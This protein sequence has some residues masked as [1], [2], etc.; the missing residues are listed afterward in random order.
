MR[1]EERRVSSDARYRVLSALV[2]HPLGLTRQALASAADVP[3]ATLATI[4][5]G[6][7]GQDLSAL[8]VEAK[9]ERAAPGGGP[10]PKIVRLREGICV[11]GV[12]IGHG[13]IRVGIAGLDGR[14]WPDA[15]GRH[16]DQLVMPVFKE[17]RATLNWIAGGLEGERGALSQRLARVFAERTKN[18]AESSLKKPLVVG[19]GISV[20]GPVDPQDGRLVCVRPADGLIKD[21]EGSIACADWDGESAGKGLRD[22]LRGAD[23]TEMFGWTLSH[24]RSDSASELCAKAELSRGVLSDT[25]FAIFVKWTGNV[26][27]AVVLGGEVF[28]GS[29]GLAGGFPMHSP[30]VP[31][32]NGMDDLETSKR[33]PLGIA[34][35]IH[36]LGEEI[37]RALGL[38]T[39]RTDELFR[40]YFRAEILSISRGERDGFGSPEMALVN[41]CL[42]QA[43]TLLG[44]TLAPTVDMLDPSKVVIGGGIFE[45]QD[46]IVAEFLSEGMRRKVT[47][48]G[49]APDV[50]LAA[51]VEHPALDGAIASRLHPRDV[52]PVLLEACD[53]IS[54]M[55]EPVGLHS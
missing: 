54:S 15:Q 10:R 38:R 33:L 53:A 8:I 14:L 46:W 43:G 36:R 37:G 5:R 31:A 35:G 4:L 55:G 51:H 48:P 2:G 19:V 30:T 3:A 29:R 12:E 6:P 25:D 7:D 40:D 52:V 9:A 23:R 1:R 50:E 44:K 47:A 45:R 16:Y 20:A 21:E 39:R 34:V 13:H 17:R 11:A 41:A 28:A 49:K 26:S 32:D 18:D 24:F 27:A 42:G 22:R